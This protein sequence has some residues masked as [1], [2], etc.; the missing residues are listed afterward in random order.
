MRKILGLSQYKI[1]TVAEKGN[2]PL[3][4]NLCPICLNNLDSVEYIKTPCGHVYHLFCLE[5]WVRE[6]SECPTCRYKLL[7]I[8]DD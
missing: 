3:Q 2:N 1:F 4:E 7:Q 6:K 5:Q 8:E